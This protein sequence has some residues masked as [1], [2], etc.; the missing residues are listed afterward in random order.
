MTIY[1]CMCIILII[2]TNLQ[3]FNGLRFEMHAAWS[4]N[5]RRLDMLDVFE[6]KE[7]DI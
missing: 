1:V 6:Q 5:M 2:K 4:L 3:F 7:E